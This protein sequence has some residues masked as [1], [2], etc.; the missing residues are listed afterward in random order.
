MDIKPKPKRERVYAPSGGKLMTKQE[1][2]ASCDINDLV[3]RAIQSGGIIPDV[4]AKYGDFVGAAD[5][6]TA[7]NRILSA[8]QDFML[9][10]SQLRAR[11][12]NDPAQ[13]LDFLANA[14]NAAESV[15]LGLREFTPAESP[16]TQEV[17]TNTQTN[18]STPE[19]PPAE[20]A[21]TPPQQ[22]KTS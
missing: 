12:E 7:M 6:Q 18:T 11:F 16:A 20:A 2:K 22:D 3:A 8:Q 19:T 17:E 14:D 15:E 5:F 1:P 21:P 9:L 13:L 10:P 4:R